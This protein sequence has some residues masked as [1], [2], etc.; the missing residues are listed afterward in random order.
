MRP[1]TDFFSS[2]QTGEPAGNLDEGRVAEGAS[3]L[4]P[5]SGPL[6]TVCVRTCDGA[7]FPISS[8]ATPLNFEADAQ[9]CR[10]MCPGARAEL[11]YHPLRS[12]ESDDMV[13][14]ETGR[15]YSEMP[16]AYA[17]RDTTPSD[18]PAC[19]CNF[20]AYYQQNMPK[21]LVRRDK[22]SYSSVTHIPLV[23][24]KRAETK[25]DPRERDYDPARDAA[26]QVG[27][28]FVPTETTSIDL[29]HPRGDGVQ[30]QQ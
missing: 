9:T 4:P 18:T 10:Q 21:G 27:P 14:A 25:I 6:R 11:F 19:S 2:R 1:S 17:Y 23:P 24:K 22:H 15:P 8:H 26:R 7:F 20:S 30:P 12:P 16:N 28:A 29:M 5:D 13:S 3:D